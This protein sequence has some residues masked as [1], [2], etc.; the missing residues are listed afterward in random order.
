MISYRNWT[1]GS[2]AFSLETDGAGRGRGGVAEMRC[3]R[4]RNL[5]KSS[6]SDSELN[7]NQVSCQWSETLGEGGGEGGNDSSSIGSNSRSDQVSCQWSEAVGE[8]GG[9]GGND[10]SSI[11]SSPTRLSNGIWT[12]GRPCHGN[13]PSSVPSS[14]S[15]LS[16]IV[17]K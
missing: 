6:E 11:G 15:R 1:S 9:E 14:C 8:G 10:S 13:L 3:R 5:L 4:V 12:I 16:L 2:S 17:K 7:S